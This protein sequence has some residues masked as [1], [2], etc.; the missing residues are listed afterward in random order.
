MATEQEVSQLVRWLASSGLANPPDW[1][2]ITEA[3][4]RHIIQNFHAALRDIQFSILSA[5]VQSYSANNTWWPTPSEIRR[6][7]I[8]LVFEAMDF[9]SSDEAWMEVMRKRADQLA[10]SPYTRKLPDDFSFELIEQTARLIGWN[11]I[12]YSEGEN[13]SYLRHRFDRLYNGE[14]ER[15]NRFLKQPPEVKAIL[16][17]AKTRRRKGLLRPGDVFAGFLEAGNGDT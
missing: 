11:S 10:E 6:T 4:R 3:Q 5:A 12:L 7:A 2:G 16:I 17:E 15:W 13:Q 8:D 9:P 14:L 1:N